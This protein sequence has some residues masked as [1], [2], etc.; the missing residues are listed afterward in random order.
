M[1][2]RIRQSTKSVY[3][4][5]IFG[6]IILVFVFW[7]IGPMRDSGNGNSVATVDG[8]SIEIK[9]YLKIRRQMEN[10]YRNLLKGQYTPEMEKRIGIKRRAVTILIDRALAVKE[11][12]KT[13]I[14]VSKKEVQDVIASMPAFQKDGVFDRE[15]YFRSLKAERMQPAEFEKAVEDDLITEKVRARVTKDIT[16]SDEEVTKA[17]LTEHRRINLKYVA[18]DAAR[19]EDA[20]KVSDEEARNYLKEHSSDFI[21]PAKIK[22][23]YVHAGYGDFMKGVRV[24]DADIKEYYEKNKER[25]LNPGEVRASHILVRPDMENPDREA[26]KA[27]A[28]KKAEALL[29]RL[30]EGADFK[31]MAKKYSQDPGSGKKGGDLGWFPRGVMVKTFED[32]AFS[33]KKGELSPI[34]ETVFGF[35]IIRVEDKK[36]PTLKPLKEV[37]P[38][39]IKAIK[40]DRARERAY[41][42][43]KA[44]QKPFEEAKDIEGL[45]KIVKKLRGLKYTVTGLMDSKKVKEEFK[46][47]Q[48]MAENLFLMDEGEVS[49]P[50]KTK[51]GVHMVK[52]VKRIDARLPKYEEVAS[53]IKAVVR[54]KKA[55]ILAKKEAESLLN[56]LKGGAGLEPLAK[57]KKLRVRET[58]F[59]SMADGFV[60]VLGLPTSNYTALFGLSSEKP[61]FET[62]IA[63]NATF[64]ILELK[65]SKEADLKQ[66]TPAMKEELRVRLLNRKQEEALNKWLDS[67][68]AKAK[69]KVYEDRM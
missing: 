41:S 19:F 12:K 13:G 38:S 48:Y 31:E 17:F 25:F 51:D 69:I 36:E 62:V 6:I 66:L 56:A 65:A 20:V 59:F 9:D 27:E 33:L 8:Q 14:K 42:A 46:G 64:Y 68:R 15:T 16:V 52:I 21:E 35:H 50:L 45:K 5:F 2:E 34:V 26:A 53:K 37:T 10:Y 28:R 7:G 11:A 49:S 4:L 60:P 39:I 1:L 47:P 24:T 18:M 58:G 3:I 57:K 43:I 30:R 22:V 23:F 29:Q 61:L 54:K 67:L 40:T 55:R 32:A 63:R 44:L